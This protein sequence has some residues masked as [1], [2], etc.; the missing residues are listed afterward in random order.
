MKLN[1][2]LSPLEIENNDVISQSTIIEKRKDWPIQFIKPNGFGY[3]E[4]LMPN[5]VEIKKFFLKISKET[6]LNGHRNFINRNRFHIDAIIQDRKTFTPNILLTDLDTSIKYS[7]EENDFH[8]SAENRAEICIDKEVGICTIVEPSNWGS[9]LVRAIPKAIEFKAHGI[10]KIF[11]WANHP[12]QFEILKL[13]GYS[14]TEIHLHNPKINFRFSNGYLKSDP[15]PGL[16]LEPASRNLLQQFSL[17]YRTENNSKRIY[18]SR[19]SALGQR[20]GRVCINE[21]DVENLMTT[22]GFEIVYPEEN[23]PEKIVEL[24]SNA[25]IIVGCSGASMFNCVFCRPNTFVIDIESQPNWLWGHINLFSSLQLKFHIFFAEPI[26]KSGSPHRPFFVD[27]LEL[28]KV[29]EKLC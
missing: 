29:L 28:K 9:F 2:E 5:S 20:S 4:P 18:V 21:E 11:I 8:L 25:E 14:R 17:K 12:N 19:K 16:Y 13:I 24:F 23:T 3:K 6:L 26:E 22:I 15:A 27:T 7:T 1:F 10:N